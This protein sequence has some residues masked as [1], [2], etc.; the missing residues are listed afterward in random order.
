MSRFSKLRSFE[1]LESRQLCAADWQNAVNAVDV[2]RSGTVEPLD[3][4]I[5]VNDLNEHG[6]RNLPELAADYAG[7]LCDVSGDGVLSALDALLVVNSLNTVTVGT[8][9][10]AVR[11]PNQDGEL[12]DLTSF[13]G[14][15]AVVLYFYPK[16]NTPGCTI[17]A[18]DFSDRKEQIESLGAK[19]YGVSLDSVDSH[20]EF[21]TDHVLSFDIL[22]DEN[23]Q[24]TLAYGVLTQLNNAPFARRTTFIIGKDGVI[25]QVFTDVNVATH[26]GEVVA[27][28]QAGIGG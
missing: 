21:A 4:L 2:N 25:K 17:E 9:A 19:I 12:I 14:E 28:L 3:A 7:P 13:I 5:V 8:I 6:D 16:D 23:K 22:A 10:P 20:E 24:V 11:L 26:G 1:R 18:L 27:A 15:A